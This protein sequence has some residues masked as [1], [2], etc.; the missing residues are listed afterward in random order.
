M[1][2]FVSITFS[3]TLIEKQM[4]KE[5]DKTISTKTLFSWIS[6]LFLS[7]LQTKLKLCHSAQRQKGMNCLLTII[8]LF[9]SF[10]SLL[11]LFILFHI[12]F[13][14]NNRL[15]LIIDNVGCNYRMHFNFF[16]NR[17]KILCKNYNTIKGFIRVRTIGF[18]TLIF[19]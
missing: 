2:V 17:Y 11:P 4:S 6:L 3:I 16:D 13:F 10:P 7:T 18:Y 9:F 19:M 8:P 5:I 15:L 14:T 1:S 12:V